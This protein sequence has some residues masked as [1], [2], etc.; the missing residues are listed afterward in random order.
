MNGSTGLLYVNT[1]VYESIDKD[2][3]KIDGLDWN[4]AFIRKLCR[5]MFIGEEL[6]WHE[7]FS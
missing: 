7:W 6:K 3:N 2:Y 4:Q 5:F 1:I